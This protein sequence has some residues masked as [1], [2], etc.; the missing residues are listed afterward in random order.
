LVILAAAGS[1]K[2]EHIID[3]ALAVED[4]RV[5]ITTF[6]NENQRQII[7]RIEGRLGSV[8]KHITVMGW[9]AFLVS[10]CAKPY[11][12]ALTQKPLS[13]NGLNFK[14][15][16]NRFAKRSEPGYYIDRNGDMYRDGVSDFVV[17]LDKKVDG[18]VVRRLERIYT[19]ILV[20]E[21]QD[22]VGYDLEVLDM[23]MTSRINVVLVGDPRQHTFSTNT[24]S[25]NK[26]YR[27]S[28]LAAWFA[29]RTALCSIEERVQSYRC[30]QAICDFADAIYPNL[31]ATKSVGVL[32]TEHDGII[33]VRLS[34]VE[35]YVGRFRPV[36]LRYDRNADTKGLPAI[37][38]GVSKGSTFDRVMIFPTKP[39][40]Q[41]LKDRDPE[42]LKSPE[43]LYVAVTRARFSVA[44]VVP[45]AQCTSIALFQP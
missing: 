1:R 35:E 16:R 2:T 13:I 7:S 22:F 9:F 34:D 39:M 23:L 8:P 10:Q 36:A 27:G 30:C 18:A 43:K 11:Q 21:V 14:G 40:L 44:F 12:R 6:T 25:K 28:G 42:K 32:P 41:Y 38:I 24:A 20:D 33:Q 3:S 37:N 19:H 17:E 4:G 31:P 15:Q 45:N 26:R 29:K 5:L